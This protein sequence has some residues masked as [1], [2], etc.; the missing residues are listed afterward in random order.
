MLSSFILKGLSSCLLLLHIL[1]SDYKEFFKRFSSVCNR[2]MTS[3]G[4]HCSKLIIILSYVPVFHV[5]S[6]PT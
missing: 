3:T 2:Y 5:D 6:T 1:Y 4:Q